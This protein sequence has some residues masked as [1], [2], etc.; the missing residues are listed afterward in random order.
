MQDAFVTASGMKPSL[1]FQNNSFNDVNGGIGLFAATVSPFDFYKDFVVDN[2]TQGNAGSGSYKGLV[3]IDGSGALRPLGTQTNFYYTSNFHPTSSTRV[4]YSS[5]LDKFGVGY[6]FANFSNNPI[7][8]AHP[9]FASSS[10]AQSSS[11]AQNAISATSASF[12]TIANGLNP[13]SSISVVNV[14]GSG[15]LQ[16]AGSDINFANLPVYTNDFDAAAGGV[17]VGSIYRNGN[18]IQI[19]IS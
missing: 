7:M 11:L 2:N 3:Y 13:G 15:N 16:I 6:K 1:L 4:D 19:R 14:T 12:A 5:S 17:R 9:L 18:F 8:V 10:F